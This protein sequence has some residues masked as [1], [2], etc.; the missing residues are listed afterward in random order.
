MKMSNYTLNLDFILFLHY[1]SLL[2]LQISYHLRK[3]VKTK[4]CFFRCLDFTKIISIAVL[5][6]RFFSLLSRIHSL[7]IMPWNWFH[8]IFVKESRKNN[9]SG[10]PSRYRLLIV[11]WFHEKKWQCFFP[12]SRISWK[13]GMRLL[14]SFFVFQNFRENTFV[15]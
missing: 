2:N 8:E 15:L 1:I 14:Q 5:I 12:I 6:D 13:H 11:L 10:I 3:F 4:I 7:K 9:S